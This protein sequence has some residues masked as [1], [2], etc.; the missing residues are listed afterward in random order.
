MSKFLPLI[1]EQLTIYKDL[2]Y[3]RDESSNR[4]QRYDVLLAMDHFRVDVEEELR[5]V[6]DRLVRDELI[7]LKLAIDSVNV[8]EKVPQV[9]RERFH[10]I[11]IRLSSAAVH[12][13]SLSRSK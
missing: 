9:V 6:V 7:Y 8:C 1:N 11:R 2:F 4:E 5:Q 13:N 12:S 3:E 10:A